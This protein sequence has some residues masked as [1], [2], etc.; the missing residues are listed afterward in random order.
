MADFTPFN[1]LSGVVGLIGLGLIIWSI[2]WAYHDAEE[3]GKSGCLVAIMIAF[4][5]WP[6]SLIV[7]LLI[8]PDEKLNERK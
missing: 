4:L 3:R 8:R 1:I 7:W 5:S 6:I 2:F